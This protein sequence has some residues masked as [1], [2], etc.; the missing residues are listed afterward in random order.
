MKYQDILLE[1][2]LVEH[3][4]TIEKLFEG[5]LSNTVSPTSLLMDFGVPPVNSMG[6]Q[7]LAILLGFK[8]WL[9]LEIEFLN[10]SPN[11][12]NLLKQLKDMSFEEW[13]NSG[14]FTKHTPDSAYLGNKIKAAIEKAG[15]T[16]GF[17]KQLM[18]ISKKPEGILLKLLS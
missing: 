16:A 4:R 9:D 8:N 7:E 12:M 18:K 6:K 11:P 15:G 13:K 14:N 5:M 10:H 17:I 1:M 2:K 3:K